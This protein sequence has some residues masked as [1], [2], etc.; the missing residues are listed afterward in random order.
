MKRYIIALILAFTA[1]Q[2]EAQIDRSKAP[3]SNQAPEIKMGEVKQFQ[4]KNGLNVILVENH[5][6]PQVRVSLDLDLPP[7]QEGKKAGLSSFIGDMLRSGTT[8]HTKEELD[9]KMDALGSHFWTY[10]EGAG[11][12][13]LTKQLEP[14]VALLAE[15]VK[16][17]NFTNQKE[18]D[19]L[20]KQQITAL[21]ADAKNPDAISLQVSDILLFGKNHPYGEYMT[22]ETIQNITLSDIKEYC[23][24]YFNASNGYL[25]ITGDISEK[26][27]KKLAKKYFSDWKKGVKA[28]T[29][30]PAP[31]NVDQTEINIINLPSATQ[32]SINITNLAPLKKSNTDFFAARLANAILGSGGFGSRLFQNIREDKGWTYGAYS[33]LNPDSDIIGVFY[34]SS[35]VRNEVTDSAVVEF[36]KELHKITSE[37]PTFNEV[38]NMKAKSTGT[39][40]LQLERPETAANFVL[41]QITDHLGDDFYKNYLKNLNAVTDAEIVTAAKKYIKPHQ[42]RIIIVGKADDIVPDLRKLNYPIRFYDR[43]GNPVKDPTI[44]KSAG[45]AT[46]QS[47]IDGYLKAIGGKEKLQTITSIKEIYDANFDAIP[48]PLKV[49]NLKVAPNQFSTTITIPSMN[50]SLISKLVFDGKK[51]YEQSPQSKNDFDAKKVEEL[52]NE[53]ALFPQL[54]YQNSV[55]KGIVELNKHDVYEVVT[56]KKTE[57]YNT[58][59]YLLE[60]EIRI[61]NEGGQS[62]PFTTD[63]SNYKKFEG[64]LIPYSNELTIPNMP[65][66][67]KSTLK[68]I[69][70]NV[71]TSDLDF[72]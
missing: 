61:E 28:Q 45:K 6:L 24:Q 66:S 62:V 34:A 32:S 29:S 71:E 21:E 53:N 67:I 52:K 50:N 13:S 11:V 15:M 56:G 64:V 47:V 17:A 37:K 59:T 65:G 16:N 5:K 60:R 10:S 18:L 19:K 72:Q 68:E 4:L 1:S 54:N 36:M 57:Y 39:F 35:K 43:F 41:E 46:A 63:F 9:L 14:S 27:A 3:I 31:D 70:F 48:A 51:G 69:E 40:A 26:Q 8:E 49:Y 42:A 2:I 55:L 12:T 38:K 20:K 7:I 44:K 58:Q 30:F 23:H 33:G 22:E 25:T